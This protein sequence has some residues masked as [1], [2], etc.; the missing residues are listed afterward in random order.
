[1]CAIPSLKGRVHKTV[2]RQNV[3]L[4]EASRLRKPVMYYDA[5]CTGTEDYLLL[6][7]EIAAQVRQQVI[8]KAKPAVS[9]KSKSNSRTTRA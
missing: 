5:E 7:K 4:T 1:V 9:S 3:K 2:V 6:S 8:A